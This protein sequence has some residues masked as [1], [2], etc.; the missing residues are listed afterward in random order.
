MLAAGLLTLPAAAGLF[1]LAEPI[2]ALLFERGA[3]TAIDSA[4][5][6]E[7]LRGF[8]IGLPAFVFIKALQPSFFARRDTARAAG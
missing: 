8:C 6:A 7:V 2:V 3:F 4:V 5:T 1:A